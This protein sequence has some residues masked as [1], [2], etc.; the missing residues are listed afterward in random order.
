MKT[1]RVQECSVSKASPEI[2]PEILPDGYSRYFG[3]MIDEEGDLAIDC[4]AYAGIIPCRNG[5]AIQIDPK[6]KVSDLTYL[7]LKSGELNRSLDTPF[8][9]TVAYQIAEK[10]VNS[11]FEALISSFLLQIDMIKRLGLL[12]NAEI[13]SCNVAQIKGKLNLSRFRTTYSRSL[14]LRIDCW[15]RDYVLNNSPNRLLA[16]C[17]KYL[18]RTNLIVTDRNEIVNRM[19]YFAMFDKTGLEPDDIYMVR[20]LVEKRKIP[21]SRHYYIPALNLALLILQGAGITLGD[22]REVMFRPLIINTSKMFES[23]VRS[24][25]REIFRGT[26]VSVLSGNEFSRFFYDE[27]SNRLSLSPDIVLIEGANNLGLIDVK[28]KEAPTSSDHYQ[29]WAYLRGYETDHGFFVSTTNANKSRFEVFKKNGKTVHDFSFNLA[30]IQNSEV[31]FAAF[32]K[33]ALA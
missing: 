14:G 6:V 9:E 21:S 32:L 17:L 26:Q 28:Y 4:H 7:L 11:F 24:L 15:L 10:S 5:I 19:Q 23:Y 12:R 16:Q 2:R 18:S 31:E 1:I 30:D 29:M 13:K 8:K 33:K 25:T 27:A 22:E 20:E 3:L